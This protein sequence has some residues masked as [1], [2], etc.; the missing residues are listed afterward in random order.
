MKKVYV[1]FPLPANFYVKS[2]FDTL[3]LKPIEDLVIHLYMTKTMFE[4]M[5]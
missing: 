2:T 4:N 3:D 5:V 1:L